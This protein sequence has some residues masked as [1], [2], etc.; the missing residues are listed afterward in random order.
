MPPRRLILRPAQVVHAKHRHA[1]APRAR[2]SV[3]VRRPP[4]PAP[5]LAQ[6]RKH[7]RPAAASGPAA[8]GTFRTLPRS[9]WEFSRRSLR[10]PPGT[11]HDKH[12]M[13]T[14]P[15]WFSSTLPDV[16]VRVVR[17]PPSRTGHS[18]ALCVLIPRPREETA[19][20]AR[21]TRLLGD[22]DPA[23]APHRAAESGSSTFRPHTRRPA[24][25][26]LPHAQFALHA[27]LPRCFVLSECA[28]ES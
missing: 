13:Q 6:N 17:P 21:P 23:P 15:A 1:A 16:H 12:Q 14:S 28:L 25:G 22:L 26:P 24:H 2:P 20:M 4:V 18:R 11:H 5:P 10:A 7:T 27:K 3:F 8:T 9:A 19:K